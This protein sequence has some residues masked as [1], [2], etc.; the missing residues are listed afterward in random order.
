VSKLNLGVFFGGR[1]AE[2]EIS[3]ISAKNI[4]DSVNIDKYD[5][6]PIG[7]DKKGR[8]LAYSGMD[9]ILDYRDVTRVRLNANGVPV[10]FSFGQSREMIGIE[11]RSFKITLDVI[12]PVLHGT[13]GEDGTIQGLFEIAS[14]PYVG[15]GVSGSAIGMDKEIAKRILEQSGVNIAKFLVFNIYEQEII[16]FSKIASKLG[17]PFF[18]KPARAGS[19]VGIYKINDERNFSEKINDAFR[20]SNKVLFEEAIVGR[21]VEC[22]VLGNEN[23]IVSLPGEVI[24]NHEFYSYEA[25]YVMEDGAQFKI[26]VKLPDKLIETIQADSIKIYKLLGCE[27]MARVDGFLTKNDE[28]VFNEINTIPGFTSIS[29]YPKLWSVSGIST[30]DLIDR[31]VKYAIEKFN[32]EQNIKTSFL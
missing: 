12:F 20:F 17:T 11:D 27:G 24:P 26:P 25:K 1:S 30:E 18:V 8:F 4:I 10:T 13:Y 21:E 5:I 32:R 16:S 15:A 19:S 7:I 9:Y 28:Y 6:Y 29:M 3:L 14:I 23:P 2:H 31:L 22:S